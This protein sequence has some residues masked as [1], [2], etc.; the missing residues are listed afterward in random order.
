MADINGN[1]I[2][3]EAIDFGFSM[4]LKQGKMLFMRLK[5]S[6]YYMAPNCTGETCN[7]TPTVVLF[8][9]SDTWALGIM[10]KKICNYPKIYNDIKTKSK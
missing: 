1:T 5:G 7:K 6:P 10:F 4:Q 3:I 9:A 8:I 2:V